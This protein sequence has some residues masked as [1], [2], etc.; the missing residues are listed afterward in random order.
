MGALVHQTTE[1]FARRVPS[2]NTKYSAGNGTAGDLVGRYL[3]PALIF[4]DHQEHPLFTVARRLGVGKHSAGE[5]FP[6]N[7]LLWVNTGK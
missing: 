4:L 7:K 6:R 5:F 2:L 1:R 3:V